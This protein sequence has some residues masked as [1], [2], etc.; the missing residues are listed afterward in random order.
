[1]AGETNQVKVMLEES[2]LELS[3]IVIEEE[4]GTARNLPT[5]AAETTGDGS[6]GFGRSGSTSSTASGGE[7]KLR[8]RVRERV[9]IVKNATKA[10][11]D[12]AQD[13]GKL[14]NNKGF[15]LR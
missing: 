11:L 9:L 5:S 13:V 15:I 4:F 6:K 1:M 12:S 10:T 2:L 3:N 7:L 8:R 14:S